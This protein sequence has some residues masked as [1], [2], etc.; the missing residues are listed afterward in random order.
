MKRR[1]EQRRVFHEELSIEQADNG[2][3][4][5]VGSISNT[6]IEGNLV[7]FGTQTDLSIED[8]AKLETDYQ[9][10]LDDDVHHKNTT[11]IGR[12]YPSLDDFKSSEKLNRLYTGLG[13]VTILMAIFN[14]VHE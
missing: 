7:S 3:T 14:L 8:I 12:G 6:V 13:S 4:D 11:A 9:L 5:C 1:E 2:D 10:R